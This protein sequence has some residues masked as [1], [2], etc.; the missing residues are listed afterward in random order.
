MLY[1]GTLTY[2]TPKYILLLL[3]FHRVGNTG[4]GAG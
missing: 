4:S 3:F 1:E 2:E